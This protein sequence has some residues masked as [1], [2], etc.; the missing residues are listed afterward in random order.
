MHAR[1]SVRTA[2]FAVLLL[3]MLAGCGA[4]SG[5]KPA[6]NGGKPDAGGGEDTLAKIKKAGVLKWGADASG[7]A[8]Y[9]FNDPKDADKVI[10]F[11]VE[12]MDKLAAHMGLKPERVQ[13]EWKT[14]L[15]NMKDR[16]TDVVMNGIEINEQRQK[17][18]NFSDP[19]FIYEQQLTVRA[20]DKDKFKTLED[21]KG[22]KVGILEDTESGNVLKRAGFTE[23]QIKNHPDSKT[24]YDELKIKRIDAVMAEW[25][26]ADYYAGTDKA[27]YNV[28]KTF[29]PGK[30]AIAVRKDKENDTLVAEI[31]KA[32][33]EMKDNGELAAIYKKWKIWNAQ[34]KELGIVEK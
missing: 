6:D 20:E 27:I 16:R 13:G 32:L 33:K 1:G 17:A 3:A 26:I 15:E 24:P 19:Y 23:D 25:M 9:V 7:G 10:G 28:P 5:G 4:P 34:Q 22:K 8:P 12:I 29:A 18:Y 11:E 21:L 30:Y 31:N 2:F 14:L